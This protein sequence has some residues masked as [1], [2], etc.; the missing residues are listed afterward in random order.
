VSNNFPPK[1]TV[2]RIWCPHL[3]PPHDKYCV[4]I[5]AAQGWFF[6]IN[7]NPPPFRR[8]RN[9]AIELQSFEASFLTHTSYID[10]TKCE[11]FSEEIV[12]EALS[13]PDRNI[14]FLIKAVQARILEA[15][16]LHKVLPPDV[17]SAVLA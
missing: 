5:D 12:A 15:V 3:L 6:F 14:G 13:D 7:S 4:V 16:Q 2:I 10:T 17:H 11:W 8:A 9:L 1:W